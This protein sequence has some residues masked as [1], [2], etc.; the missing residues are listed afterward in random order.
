MLRDAI[1]RWLGIQRLEG[2]LRHRIEVLES[3]VNELDECIEQLTDEPTVQ[4]IFEDDDM[5]EVDALGYV[6][7]PKAEA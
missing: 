5:P 7:P 2:Q 4:L 1:R 6:K 3:I